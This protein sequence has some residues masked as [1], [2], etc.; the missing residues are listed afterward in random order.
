MRSSRSSQ[1]RSAEVLSHLRCAMQMGATGYGPQDQPPLDHEG[2]V[3]FMDSLGRPDIS[4]VC[5]GAARHWPYGIPD[6]CFASPPKTL[7][8]TMPAL[9]VQ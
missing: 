9:N 8:L 2:W 6:L 1:D 5:P 7:M 3:E 4:K